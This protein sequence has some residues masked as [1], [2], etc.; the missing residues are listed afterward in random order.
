MYSTQ[1]RPRRVAGEAGEAGEGGRGWQ[2]L[3]SSSLAV[4]AGAQ[5]KQGLYLEVAKKHWNKIQIPPS[6]NFKIALRA[7]GNPGPFLGVFPQKGPG[8]PARFPAILGFLDG[9]DLFFR[10]FSGGTPKLE[11]FPVLFA[12]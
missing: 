11:H 8:V 12:T 4:L 7:A 9:G 6:K 10:C 1:I 2:R 5:G 3:P